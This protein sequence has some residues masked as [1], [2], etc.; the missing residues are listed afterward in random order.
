MRRV[1]MDAAV[2]AVS[3]VSKA[4]AASKHGFGA[5]SAAAVRP[6][7][8]VQPAA[9][10]RAQGSWREGFVCVFLECVCVCLRIVFAAFTAVY[11]VSV[12][13]STLC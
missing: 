12:L 11:S 1:A 5:V 6:Q 9:G 3:E 7:G 13:C 10:S 8:P 2:T 4:S